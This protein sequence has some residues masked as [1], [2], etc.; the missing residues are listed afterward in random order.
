MAPRPVRLDPADRRGP[1]HR[2]PATEGLPHAVID[3]RYHLVSLISVFL[4]LAIGII[5][6]AGPLREP[7]G[8]SLTQQVE[9]LREDRD[10]LRQQAQAA[11]ALS[12]AQGAFVEQSAPRLL[13]DS[14]NDVPVVVIGL[15]SADDEVLAGLQTRLGEAGAGPVT[16]VTLAEDFLD[17]QA[18]DARAA[19]DEI[20]PGLPQGT[21]GLLEALA[22]GVS[23]AAQSGSGSDGE[24]AAEDGDGAPESG[25][26]GAPEDYL[27]ALVDA[28]LI[29][30]SENA[31]PDAR[32]AIVVGRD[33]SAVQPAP[34]E[35]TQTAGPTEESDPLQTVDSGATEA[36]TGFAHSLENRMDGVVVA[37]DGL[38]ATEGLVA[39][40]RAEEPALSTVDGIVSPAG[41]VIAVLAGAE[42]LDG[43]RGDYGFT[44]DEL[45]PPEPR[46][47]GGNDQQDDQ[48]G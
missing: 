42:Q 22:R 26:P 27:Q 40:L 32:L 37:G 9:S 7:I 2:L 33:H 17:A 21:A 48:E 39:A 35:E 19:L 20:D 45:L 29:G 16:T 46:T 11:E 23:P 31:A 44:A 34:A 38:S 36:F 4:A 43:G 3:F 47:A 15:P 12:E 14:L 8:E 30:T 41:Q 5:L 18:D 25:E 6:G 1:R 10:Q 28:G 24:N 13:R